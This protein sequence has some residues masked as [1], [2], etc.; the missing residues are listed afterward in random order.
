MP[1]AFDLGARS[2]K[3]LHA[4]CFGNSAPVAQKRRGIIVRRGGDCAIESSAILQHARQ[5]I[6]EHCRAKLHREPH[7]RFILV[8]EGVVQRGLSNLMSQDIPF[9]IAQDG[10]VRVL[11]KCKRMVFQNGHAEGMD[12]GDAGGVGAAL[13]IAPKRQFLGVVARSAFMRLAPETLLHLARRAFGKR[14][15]DNLVQGRVAGFQQSQ[16]ALDEDHR[17]PGAGT[18]IDAQVAPRDLDRVSLCFG[19]L[20]RHGCGSLRAIRPASY[21]QTRR[22]S[23]YVHE[24]S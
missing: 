23:Q 7:D 4:I 16:H 21:R 17:L 9:G 14:D 20:S 3:P 11:P 12:G 10:E 8:L 19:I 6:D 5:L 18:R 24:S 2:V 1:D 15:R 13:D 22:I